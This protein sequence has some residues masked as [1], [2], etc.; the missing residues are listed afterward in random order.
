MEMVMKVAAG[1]QAVP[2]SSH[3]MDLRFV[4]DSFCGLS[5]FAAAAF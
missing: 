2:L 5:L 4:C 3:E 1:E